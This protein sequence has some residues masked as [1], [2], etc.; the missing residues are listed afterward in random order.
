[1]FKSIH[2]TQSTPDTFIEAY[3][4]GKPNEYFVALNPVDMPALYHT[5]LTFETEDEA[6]A[7]LNTRATYAGDY[8]T[9]GL[10]IDNI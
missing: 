10:K 7:N 6:I 3:T 8:L 1:M 4:F 2:K 9:V 5:A